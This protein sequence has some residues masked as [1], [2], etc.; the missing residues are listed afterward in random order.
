MNEINA[1]IDE[2]LAEHRPDRYEHG[3][4]DEWL[5]QLAEDRIA[6]QLPEHEVRKIL[7]RDLVR[8]R[9]GVKTQE[10]NRV[11]RQIGETGQPPLDGWLETLNL[12]L[13][14]GKERV[15]MRAATA[16]D[17]AHFATDERRRAASDFAARNATCEA[18][19]WMASR[20]QAEGVD[21]ARDL[22]GEAG[23]EAA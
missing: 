11:L 6:S 22:F 18:A 23:G 9:E 17:L 5:D 19:E 13:A 14:V 15:A 2:L 16:E 10:T 21:Y 4:G 20:M 7:A 12:P 3:S 8:R 1:L